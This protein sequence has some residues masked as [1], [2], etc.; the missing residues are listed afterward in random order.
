MLLPDLFRFNAFLLFSFLESRALLRLNSL[1][2][3]GIKNYL[4]K[5]YGLGSYLDK[6]L[7]GN[8]LNRLFKRKLYG[9]YKGKLFVSARGTDSSKMLF[10]TYV[11]LNVVGY[12]LREYF[13]DRVE[14][15]ANR[16][17]LIKPRATEH[18]DTKKLLLLRLL[19]EATAC[20]CGIPISRFSER[21]NAAMK[22]K[23]LA[24]AYDLSARVAFLLSELMNDPDM[25]KKDVV[26][27]TGD[28]SQ[29]KYTMAG[30]M[31]Y[32]YYSIVQPERKNGY[33]LKTEN[34]ISFLR[35]EEVF[36]KLLA[37]NRRVELYLNGT[38]LGRLDTFPERVY[39]QYLPGQSII[40]DN[41]EY[42]IESIMDGGN[43]IY[44][45]QENITYNSCMVPRCFFI[46]F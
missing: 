40:F 21:V 34:C 41:C 31:V 43:A 1:T 10:L 35:L 17:D 16:S 36:D 45:R 25:I 9:S 15:Y 7:V 23:G 33:E 27:K 3:G 19:C 38:M 32:N 8:K 11:Y 22:E 42:E 14:M 12:L 46:V 26:K 13:G 44:L 30:R 18:A 39:Q 5:S 29:V 4:T 20:D 2:G 37:N 24:P 28:G 6:L